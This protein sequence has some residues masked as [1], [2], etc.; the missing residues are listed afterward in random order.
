MWDWQNPVVMCSFEVDR[1]Q[2]EQLLSGQVTVHLP[3]LMLLCCVLAL[4][5]QNGS[6][7][8]TGFEG[9][10]EVLLC[11]A[12]CKLAGLQCSITQL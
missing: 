9:R 4:L 11:T 6:C 3:G 1:V 12:A 5:T 2:C 7:T 8:E 10:C